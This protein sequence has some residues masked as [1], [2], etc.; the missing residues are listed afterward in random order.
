MTL[1]FACILVLQLITKQDNTY[2]A[3]YMFIIYL[4]PM[5]TEYIATK[6]GKNNSYTET[7]ITIILSK[8]CSLHCINALLLENNH[9]QYQLSILLTQCHIHV[10]NGTDQ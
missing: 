1:I 2:T 10:V 6:T 9:R 4:Y 7:R 5:T 8:R 3:P